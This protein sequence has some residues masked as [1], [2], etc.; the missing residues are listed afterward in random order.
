MK[1]PA[2]S[3]WLF[4]FAFLFTASAGMAQTDGP[5]SPGSTGNNSG[6]GTT[7]WSSPGNSTSSNNSYS[8]VSTKGITRYLTT[9]NY[10][11]S[12]PAPSGIAGIQLDVERSTSSPTAVSL[13]NG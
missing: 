10:G 2:A 6:V 7:N 1:I 8:T 9:S 4:A 5:R 3:L 11:F 12:I 13:L